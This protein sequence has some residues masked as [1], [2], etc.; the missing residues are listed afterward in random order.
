MP[1][2]VTLSAKTTLVVK[3]SA[4]A[5]MIALYTAVRGLSWSRLR[6]QFNSHAESMFR[7]SRDIA[8]TPEAIGRKT[9]LISFAAPAIGP[10]PLNELGEPL[11]EKASLVCWNPQKNFQPVINVFANHLNDKSRSMFTSIGVIQPFRLFG[12]KSLPHY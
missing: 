9:K 2:C 11:H 8:E 7:M 12:R 6:E 4:D 1:V 5:R 3:I 10:T